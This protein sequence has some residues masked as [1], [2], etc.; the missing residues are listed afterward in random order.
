[1]GAGRAGSRR[2]K[3]HPVPGIDRFQAQ[4]TLKE[5]RVV[6]S[7]KNDLQETST[8]EPSKSALMQIR[9]E[10]LDSYFDALSLREPV[11]TSLENAP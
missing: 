3:R 8:T 9:P 1:M 10:A 5:R 2:T 11:S 6:I 7:A 4:R